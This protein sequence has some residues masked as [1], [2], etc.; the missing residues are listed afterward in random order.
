MFISCRS[1]GKLAVVK[2]VLRENATQLRIIQ[3][4]WR[5]HCFAHVWKSIV[6]VNY[7]NFVVNM[8]VTSLRIRLL[9]FNDKKSRANRNA[10]HNSIGE[11]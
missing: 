1:A 6:D 4:G 10:M 7:S 2:G 9:K 8:I 3:A 11:I 5:L